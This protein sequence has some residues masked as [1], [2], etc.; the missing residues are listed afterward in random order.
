MVLV[1]GGPLGEDSFSADHALAGFYVDRAG[2]GN[3]EV[4]T[5]A[6]ANHA[7][8]FTCLDGFS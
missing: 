5:G 4:G 7:E 6:E 8:A 3:V 1:L 2:G